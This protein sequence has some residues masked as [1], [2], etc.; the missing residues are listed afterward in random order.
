[1]HYLANPCPSPLANPYS[2]ILTSGATPNS[3]TYNALISAYGKVGQLNKAL[4]VFHTMC[5]A[6]IE[7]SVIT[8]SSLISA[9]EKAGEANAALEVFDEMKREGCTPNTVTF[10]SLLAACAAGGEWVSHD[11]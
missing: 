10:N 2:S 11:P 6:N 4:E 9:C 3:T 5:R 1:M 8:Y 7:R